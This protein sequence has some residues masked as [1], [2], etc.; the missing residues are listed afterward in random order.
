M[1]RQDVAGESTDE[2]SLLQERFESTPDD[3]GETLGL[4]FIS[5]YSIDP[6]RWY[7]FHFIQKN[8]GLWVSHIFNAILTLV[9]EIGFLFYFI[10]YFQILRV[11]TNNFTAFSV[12]NPSKHSA[13]K[14]ICNEQVHRWPL[15]HDSFAQ[16]HRG[17]FTHTRI[18]IPY[19]IIQDHS[20]AHSDVGNPLSVFAFIQQQQQVSEVGIE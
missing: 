16:S 11:L 9:L 19:H 3:K 13:G 12:H 8:N 18:H 7:L 10:V 2:Q 1:E 4:T 20:G 15:G 5:F 14:Y 17:A 6:V